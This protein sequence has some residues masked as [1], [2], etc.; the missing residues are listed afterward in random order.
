M[1]I[2]FLF[3]A[4]TLLLLLLVV[5][6]ILLDISS[7]NRSWRKVLI[8]V[9]KVMLLLTAPFC[10]ITMAA[11]LSTLGFWQR[12]FLLLALPAT[13]VMLVMINIGAL[14]FILLFTT[15]RR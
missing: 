10:Y 3:N 6:L 12:V 7:D 1:N 4:A 11:T 8:K 5:L 14:A 15:R 2:Y 13:Q 9:G